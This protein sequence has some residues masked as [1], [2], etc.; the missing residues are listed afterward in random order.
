MAAAMG[1]ISQ[2]GMAASAPATE[3]YDLISGDFGLI[4]EHY[5]A[6]GTTGT[7]SKHAER[8]RANTRKATGS[9]TF[10]PNAVELSTLLP[11]ILG[12]SASGTD[13]PLAETLPSFTLVI[14]KVTKVFTFAT[15]YVN[16]ATFRSSQGQPLEVQLDIEG[17]D[18]SVGNA[19]TFP[20][21][22]LNLTGGGPFMHSDVVIAVGGSNYS[23]R[24]FEMIVDNM[25]D[26]E[27][28]FNA[29]SR[30]SIPSRGRSIT[31]RLDG[32]Y[33]DNSALYNL[34]VTGVAALATFTHSTATSLV[35]SS[36][37]VC[38]PRRGPILNGKEEI[39]LPLEGMAY[40]SSTT[41]ELV[42]TLDS[43]P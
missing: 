38:F 41:R 32:P 25:L 34:T 3:L 29:T 5:Q 4:E 21:I 1:A 40:M 11:R 24:S 6:D 31:W 16:R 35:F 15:C 17:L 33:G 10:Q 27:R 36:A 18:E 7:R 12:G 14:D 19:G 22:S 23:F 26:T 30:A 28:F 13:Y 37:K 42:T 9:L 2:V 20:A 39:M 43:T 8:N